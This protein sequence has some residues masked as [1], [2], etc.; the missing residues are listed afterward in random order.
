VDSV[1]VMVDTSQIPPEI[2]PTAVRP[3]FKF[4]NDDFWMQGL[5]VGLQYDF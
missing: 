1:D 2:D 4:H 3:E 5:S